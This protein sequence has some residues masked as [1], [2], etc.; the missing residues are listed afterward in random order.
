MAS[1]CKLTWK[2][3]KKKKKKNIDCEVSRSE[4]E[5]PN[6]KTNKM[7]VRPAETQ[8]SLGICQV[9]AVHSMGS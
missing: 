2:K 5:P 8:I 1:G 7:T 4:Y 3:K 6:D 9:F